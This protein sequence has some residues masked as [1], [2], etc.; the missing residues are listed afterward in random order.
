MRAAS[1]LVFICFLL[2]SCKG[3]NFADKNSSSRKDGDAAPMSDDQEET[4]ALEPTAVGG[5]YLGCFVDSQI[6]P[7]LVSGQN[8]DEMP[9][10]CQVFEDSQFTRVK[11]NNSVI[12]ES[13]ELEF[14]G[15]RRPLV[16][17][18]LPQHPRWAWVTKVPLLALHANIFLQAQAKAGSAAVRVRVELLDFLPAGL[19]TSP[20]AFLSGS[21]KLRLKDTLFC[22]DG[23]PVWGWDAAAS[24][25]IVDPI[26]I[27]VCSNA[28]NFRFTR[29]E[30]GLRIHVPNPKPLTCDT[31]NYAVEHC[32]DSCIDLENFGLGNRFVLWAC[33][34]SV[35]SQSYTLIPSTQGAIRIQGNGRPLTRFGGVLI[36]DLGTTVDFEI[37]PVAP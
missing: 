35:E 2:L 28:L 20:E 5:A 36:P 1:S 34:K 29:F 3:S 23:N 15:S 22:A 7:D 9:V 10:G 18:S 17:R 32:S 27:N 4:I 26:K 12:V 16:I 8:A 19:V 30:S 31:Q 33:T 11:T 37:L 14:S 6:S 13:G 25:P 21:Y 24:K